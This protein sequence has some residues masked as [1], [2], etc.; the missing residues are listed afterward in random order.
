MS[1]CISYVCLFRYVLVSLCIDVYS[2]LVISLF[3]HICVIHL[4]RSLFLSSVMSFVLY[5]RSYVIRYIVLYFFM[6]ASLYSSLSLS[7]S[8][9]C[10]SFFSS[11]VLYVCLSGRFPSLCM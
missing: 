6:Y 2:Y 5:V 8:L 10:L 1:L 4:C 9:S 3:L 11:F 7:L